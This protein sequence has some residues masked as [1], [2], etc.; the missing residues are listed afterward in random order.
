MSTL[1]CQK[2][3]ESK[4]TSFSSS[5]VGPVTLQRVKPS[6]C[7]LLL[8][9]DY[10]CCVLLKLNTH[11]VLT[12]KCFYFCTVG[13]LN[14]DLIAAHKCY[15]ITLPWA[16]CKVWEVT[17]AKWGGRKSLEGEGA[18]PQFCIGTVHFTCNQSNINSCLVHEMLRNWGKSLYMGRR[19][20]K[21]SLMKAKKGNCPVIGVLE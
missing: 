17:D 4:Y 13:Q 6:F 16:V 12:D 9:N 19:K 14:T 8:S 11:F 5:S 2:Q 20:E 7:S 10:S 18:H 1:K 3:Q 21:V 15:T